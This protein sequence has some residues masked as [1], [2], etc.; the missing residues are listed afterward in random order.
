MS[1]PGTARM[2]SVDEI[3]I[4]KLG[5]LHY[6][7]NYEKYIG[8]IRTQ[9]LKFLELG[10]A[11][12]DSLKY[13]ESWLPNAEIT[14]LDIT[15][16]PAHFESGRVRCYV[17][18]QQD[19]ALLD[20]VAA[21][22]AP[23]GFDVIIDDAAH[24]GQL[25]RICFWHLFENHLKPGGFYFVEDWGTGYWPQYPDGKHYSPKPVA[26]SPHERLLDRLHKSGAVQTI[27]P[28][29]KLTGWIR[30][31]L[32]R[33][34][35]GGHDRGMVGFVKELIDECGAEDMTHPDFGT[36]TPRRSRF[37]WMRISLGHVVIRKADDG[38]A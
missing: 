32:V 25:A 24:V 34:R 2:K 9:P 35:F 8:P 27:Y 4:D 3:P 23:K 7:S 15:Q 10:V 20:R 12:G 14:G 33:R 38:A 22:R 31:N 37:D 13:W 1:L 29:R 28:L 30:W 36:G 11:R 21:E 16:C 18:E 6:L 17:G 5:L 19:K 26:L